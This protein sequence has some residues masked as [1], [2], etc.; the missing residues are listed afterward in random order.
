MED[1]TD[2]L[3]KKRG[4]KPKP[5][6]E[7]APVLN[8]YR[9]DASVMKDVGGRYRT[10]SLFEGKGQTDSL[11]PVFTLEDYHTTYPSFKRLYIEI[12]DPS[13]Y[14]IAMGLLGSW[15][16]WTRLSECSWFKPIL[17]ECRE[18]L[19]AKIRSLA[20]SQIQLD[21]KVAFSEATRLAANKFLAQGQYLVES[22]REVPKEVA[23]RGRPSKEEIE[24]RT[25][26]IL[27]E[28]AVINA[29]YERINGASPK[30]H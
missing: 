28:E 12:G 2:Q 21:G 20:V 6:A 18:E 4:P 5:K 10:Q 15:E 29:D 19:N 11:V 30:A 14:A 9:L 7:Q 16:H 22:E 25:K 1:D 26:E 24:R 8:G 17:K 27:T 3:P 13:E 23:K